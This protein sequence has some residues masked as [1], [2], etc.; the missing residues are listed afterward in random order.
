MILYIFKLKTQ[1]HLSQPYLSSLL[2]SSILNNSLYLHVLS[3]LHG[4]PDLIYYVPRP[5][6]KCEMK[7]SS[8]SPDL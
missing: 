7:Q 4:A 6:T 3:P 1:F 2:P 5:T 8:V